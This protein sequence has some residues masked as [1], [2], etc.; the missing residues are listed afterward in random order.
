MSFWG[1]IVGAGAGL[2]LGGPIGG[3][4]GLVL[5][6]AI[7]AG[8]APGTDPEAARQVTFTIGVIA[9][10]AKMAKADGRVTHE[11]VAAFRQVFRVEPSEMKNVARIFDLAR[12]HTAGFEQYAHQI[13]NLMGDNRVVLGDLIDALFFIAKSDG[14]VHP[15]EKE[16]L[17]IVAGIFGYSDDEYIAI[18]QRHIGPDPNN[19]FTILGISPNASNEDI[20]TAYRNLVRENHP[21]RLIAEG[22]PSE[23]IAVATRR[24]AEINAAYDM[25][26]AQR[27]GL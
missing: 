16:Y 25:I 6:A 11:E 12:Q 23:M 24:S 14:E 8:F 3:L 2:A 21:D 27:Q 20:K 5:G 9:L 26:K 22:V 17:R 19:P 7:D 15:A 18:E 10:S 1:K 4:V 13:A